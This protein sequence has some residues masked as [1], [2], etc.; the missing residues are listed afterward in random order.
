MAPVSARRRS[1]CDRESRERSAKRFVSEQRCVH[2]NE[3]SDEARKNALELKRAGRQADTALH[4]SGRRVGR[5]ES[6]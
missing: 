4:K 5:P 6:L 1:E 2:S 3:I